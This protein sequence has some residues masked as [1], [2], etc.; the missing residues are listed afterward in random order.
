[1]DASLIDKYRKIVV[2]LGS[3]DGRLLTELA[4]QPIKRNTL[5]IGIE[6]DTSEHQKACEMSLKHNVLFIN[7]SFEMVVADFPDESVDTFISVLPHPKYVDQSFQNIWIP[8]YQI[9]LRKLKR[10]GIFIL[11]TELT[12]DLFQPVSTSAFVVWKRS[13]QTIFNTIGFETKMLRHGAPHNF[14]SHYLDHFKGDPERIKI[15]TIMLR[16]PNSS[17]TKHQNR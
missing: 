1:L 8:F 15:V 7:G 10:S 14:S 6:L 16:K 5:F 17:L 9:M 11:V 12:D 4:H 2:E 13:L 3:G